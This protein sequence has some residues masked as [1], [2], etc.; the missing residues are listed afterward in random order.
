MSWL[1]TIFKFAGR[2]IYNSIEPSLT[3]GQTVEMQ[4]D[5]NGRLK[6]TTQDT[7]T[8]W[9]DG[10]AAKAEFVI[11]STPGKVYQVFGRNSGGA[12]AYIFIFNHAAGAGS[13][14]ANGSTAAL[15]VPVK[16]PAG[17]SFTIE[18]DRPRTFS[19]GLYW[20]ASSTDNTFTYD[21]GGSFLVSAEYK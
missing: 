21:S 11:K 20:A 13:R 2:L 9:V 6:V 15:F 16:V 7:D 19:V 3:N 14:P 18:L 5:Q 4:C 1:D 17:K 8:L 10:A 12:D